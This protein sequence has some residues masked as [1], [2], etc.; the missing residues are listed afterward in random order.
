MRL[1]QY[2][3][4]ENSNA[5]TVLDKVRIVD[6]FPQ[7]RYEGRQNGSGAGVLLKRRKSQP[8]QA[9]TC[10]GLVLLK[11]LRARMLE[12]SKVDHVNLEA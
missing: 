5:C 3:R 1:G 10:M 2:A 4:Q 8:S 9:C 11:S 6:F 12:N 7:D